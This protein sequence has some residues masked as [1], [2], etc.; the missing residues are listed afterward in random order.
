ME[1]GYIH[2]PDDF[3][4]QQ[5]AKEETRHITEKIHLDVIL[6]EVESQHQMAGRNLG[7]QLEKGVYT[8]QMFNGLRHGRGKFEAKSLFSYD[9]LWY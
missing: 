5:H 6:D 7:H 3:Q 2:L 8:G 1:K 4:T 9:G